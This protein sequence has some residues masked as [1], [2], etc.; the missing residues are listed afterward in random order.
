MTGPGAH[1]PL[2]LSK[3]QRCDQVW[4]V[5]PVIPGGRLCRQCTKR[6]VDF[7][8]MSA[9]EIAMV[10]MQS[11]EPVCGM[12]REAQLRVP[13]HPAREQGVWRMHP[14]AFSLVSMLLLEPTVSLAQD[15]TTEQAAPKA[16]VVEH[17]DG[18][19][20]APA[21]AM[22]PMVVRGTVTDQGEPVPFVVVMVKGTKQGTTT[23]LDGRFALDLTDLASTGERVVL[24]MQYIGR[25]EMELEVDL[26]RPAHVAFKV[27]AG[28]VDLTSFS[29]T[30]ERPP[31]HKRIWWA[32]QRPFRKKEA[33]V[34]QH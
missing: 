19:P 20:P 27:E 33:P 11:R 23:D 18:T 2:N 8:R 25:T 10:H 1:P 31:L 5:M 26:E 29:V 14:A 9:A 34:D 24:V 7:T 3:V 12:Y 21:S 16:D 28:V 15:V 30:Y 17:P 6:I 22:D 32:I 4:D 13:D